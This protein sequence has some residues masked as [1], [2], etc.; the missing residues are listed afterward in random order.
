MKKQQKR[1]VPCLP[2][3]DIDGASVGVVHQSQFSRQG[4]LFARG[5]YTAIAD[6]D[7]NVADIAPR[8]VMLTF[9]RRTKNEGSYIWCT[10]Y[11]WNS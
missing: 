7:Q 1:F 6:A 10:S 9:A 11:H 5:V 2:E 3:I 4:H 8:W